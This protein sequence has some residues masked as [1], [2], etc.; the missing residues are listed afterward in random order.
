[1]RKSWKTE[2]R[3]LA[4]AG[5]LIVCAW[6]VSGEFLAAL[7]LG[8]SAYFVWQFYHLFRLSRWLTREK[9]ETASF[10]EGVWRELFE[11][12]RAL[13][14]INRKRKHRLSEFVIRF[15]E[16]AAVFPDAVAI[17]GP[18]GEI[19]W[20]NPAAVSFLG[21]CW[22]QCAGQPFTRQV[23]HP[24]VKE[25]LLAQDYIR[26]LE[27]FS[28]TNKA[29]VLSLHV[30]PFGKKNQQLIMV[31]D[32][33]QVYHLNHNRRDFVANASHEL[34][35]P[36]TVISGFL[37]TLADAKD[38]CPAWARS[39]D[40]M[41]QQAKRMEATIS[42]LLTLSRLEMD[43]QTH[44]SDAVPVPA[45][46]NAIIEEARA[47]SRD[48]GHV[49][50]LQAEASVWLHGDSE[51]LRSAFSN[52]VYNAVK[53]TLPRTEIHVHWHA[54]KTGAFFTVS[55]TGQGIPARHIPRLTERFY[56][57][58]KGRSRESGGTGLGLA[59]VKHVLN[60]HGAELNIV[61]EAGRG[62][63]FTCHFPASIVTLAAAWD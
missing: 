23:G 2:A 31:R 6:V 7:L 29:Q 47:L 41:Q 8:I 52:L 60:R 43:S 45:L 34:R 55:D 14:A 33:T 10:P 11:H 62:A 24:V 54:D 37:E 56:R 32:I 35:T 38:E 58:D 57:V 1:M 53:H 9:G 13:Q 19:N 25:Y 48:S 5:M 27:F 49:I 40:L 3:R 20:C 61:S 18:H 26:P 22:P 46:L 39:L 42:D 50:T 59:I 28:Q 4:K 51:E 12:I 15:R 16:A 21:L 36:L 63:A 30:T 17:L 44:K